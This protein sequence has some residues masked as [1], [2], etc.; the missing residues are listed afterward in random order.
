MRE[1]GRDIDCPRRRGASVRSALA[2]AAVVVSV[3]VVA[4]D[5][6][7][8]RPSAAA[9]SAPA[10]DSTMSALRV[11]AD[12][13][14]LVDANGTPFFWLG[15]TGWLISQKTT[16]EEAEL[17]LQT[18]ASQGFTVI[19]AALVMGEE[20]LAGTL[21]PN[22]YGD[23]PF[24]AGNPASP[25]I[26]P[27]SDPA[28]S[29][30]YDFWDHVDYIVARA[31]AHGLRLGLVPLFIGYA[32]PGYRYLTPDR[33]AAYGEFLGRRYG[34]EPHVFWILGG[35]HTPQ[36]EMHRSVWDEMARGLT[37]GAAAVEDYSRTLIGYHINGQLSSSRWFHDAPWLDF[38]MVQVWGDEPAIYQAVAS[39]YRLTPVKPTGL[40]EG[41]YE[42]SPQYPT[43]PI[44]PLKV[45]QQAYWSYFAGGYHTYGNTNT[46]SFGSFK[47]T[48][49]QD[50][51]QALHSPGAESM[52]VLARIFASLEWWR[53][54]P[55]F[56]AAVDR[57]NEPSSV[58]MRSAEGDILLT[59]ISGAGRVTVRRDAVQQTGHAAWIDP[60]TGARIPIG[61]VPMG[62]TV[63]LSTPEHWTDALLL[64]TVDHVVVSQ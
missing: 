33:S 28:R 54:V 34:S 47:E 23:Q 12:G 48:T 63:T 21:G 44:D 22:A 10:S 9:N 31:R 59:Y 13:R 7:L 51:R 49:T 8:E 56:S 52:S 46:W 15:D 6:R 39:D 62:A 36:E 57:G 27:G 29:D 14:R 60:R 30:E 16:R 64:V 42:D 11:S 53:L 35:D 17:Y 38:N 26:T 1:N 3:A 32:G 58:T 5:Q 20:F 50:W 25:L 61:E 19:Q 18:R 24:R 4:T 43:R 37:V 2:L 55:D 41:S 45:R 40:G